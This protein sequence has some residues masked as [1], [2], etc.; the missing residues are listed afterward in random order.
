[1]NPDSKVFVRGRVSAEDEAN[2]KLI[3]D[4]ITPFEEVSRRL[5][6]RFDTK[7]AYE[8]ASDELN[9]IIRESDGRDIVVIYIVEGKLKKELPRSMTVNGSE[10]LEALRARFGADNVKLV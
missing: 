1:I 5:W 10:L 6:L 4:T 3:V 9:N 7:E 2:G 8:C